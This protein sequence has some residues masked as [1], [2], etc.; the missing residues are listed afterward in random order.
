MTDRTRKVGEYAHAVATTFNK[1]YQQW[2]K[3]KIEVFPQLFSDVEKQE[4][5]SIHQHAARFCFVLFSHTAHKSGRMPVT[6]LAEQSMKITRRL[7]TH[8]CT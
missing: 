4:L 5:C 2:A 6:L 3:D 7:M 8:S 1:A